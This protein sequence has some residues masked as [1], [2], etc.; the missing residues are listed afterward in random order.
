M[1]HK[2]PNLTHNDSQ[3]THNDSQISNNKSD[4]NSHDKIIN[5]INTQYE[6]TYCNKI[7]TRKNNLITRHINKYCKKKR[8]LNEI[9]EKQIK[10]IV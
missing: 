7:F 1:T 3:M 9:D 4:V 10:E 2:I 8:L 5:N 6:C